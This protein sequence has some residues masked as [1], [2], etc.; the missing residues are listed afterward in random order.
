MSCRTR[1]GTG[2]GTPPGSSSASASW[3]SLPQ[4]ILA[5]LGLSPPEEEK[6]PPIPEVVRVPVDDEGREIQAS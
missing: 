3:T 6:P 1:I 5:E 4:I 2:S